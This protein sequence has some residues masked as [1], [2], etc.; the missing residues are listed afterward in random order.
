MINVWHEVNSILE[1]QHRFKTLLPYE[2][3][4][5]RAQS[6]SY[7]FGSWAM[8]KSIFP[9]CLG[10]KVWPGVKCENYFTENNHLIWLL[11]SNVYLCPFGLWHFRT[12]VMQFMAKN[13]FQWSFSFQIA[14]V[15]TKLNFQFRW[16]GYEVLWVLVD[17]NFLKTV[18]R[19][20]Y[21]SIKCKLD[22]FP[23]RNLIMSNNNRFSSW[24]HLNL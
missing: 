17:F 5:I 11:S 14:Q 22:S 18:C 8:D 21:M 13:N 20:S 24:V 1:Q 7:Q 4:S 2:M 23:V 9:V 6:T 10:N 12:L 3:E 19:S 16:N 15:T